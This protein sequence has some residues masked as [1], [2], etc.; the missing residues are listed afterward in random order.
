LSGFLEKNR[1]ALSMDIM[2]L[3]RKSSNKLLKQIFE[4]EMNTNSVK[5]NNKLNKIIMTPKNS[6]RVWD[7]YAAD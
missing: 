7:S 2:D 6:L 4:K 5:N 1:D 3:V